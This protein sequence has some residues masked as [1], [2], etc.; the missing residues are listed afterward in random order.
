[1]PAE[2]LHYLLVPLNLVRAV[3]VPLDLVVQR[4]AH[5]VNHLLAHDLR[6]L[7]GH[8]HGRLFLAFAGALGLHRMQQVH[9][10]LL[11][12]FER[13]FVGGVDL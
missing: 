6:H 5:H 10:H 4:T 9:I 1:M 3:L 7:G 2:L 12:G 8:P 11:N 13:V